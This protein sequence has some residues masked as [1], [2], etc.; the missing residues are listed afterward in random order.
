MSSPVRPRRS[1]WAALAGTCL[2]APSV[3]AQDGV[4]VGAG[5][6][7]APA[8]VNA[9]VEQLILDGD[10]GKDAVATVDDRGDHYV[11][12]V[13]L[14]GK[15]LQKS[16]VDASRSCE[17]R[18]RIAAV[19]IVLT[20]LPPELWPDRL[21]LDEGPASPPPAPP[22]PPPAASSLPSPPPPSPPPPPPSAPPP[23]AAA[24]LVRLELGALIEAAVAAEE[25]VAAASPGVELRG[26]I[27]SGP[28]ALTLSAGYVPEQDFE[29]NG[30]EATWERVP[31]SVGARLQSA[32]ER[33][34]YAADLGVVGMLVQA[35]SEAPFRPASDSAIDV[36]LRAGAMVSLALPAELLAFIGAH[37]L[38]LPWPREIAVAPSGVIGELPALWGGASAGIGVRL[39]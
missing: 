34:R 35:Q 32:P 29:L 36:G 39:R 25:F 37:V 9:A 15:R 5:A 26:A 6:C 31:L 23:R 4:V 13:E 3:L 28:V 7:P 10:L 16:Y 19:F 11:V 22:P 27:G 24:E 21:D 20:L 14:D 18:A 30:L 1:R 38:Y 12:S 33:V 2:L 17:R 8:T